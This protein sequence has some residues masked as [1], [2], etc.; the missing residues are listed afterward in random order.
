[1]KT[2]LCFGQGGLLAILLHQVPIG[3]TF[4]GDASGGDKEGGRVVLPGPQIRPDE[5]EI[6]RLQGI[7]FGDG[8]FDAWD[9]N[10]ALLRVHVVTLEQRHFGGPEAVMIGQL[11]EGTVTLA[12][13]D[14]KQPAHLVLSEKGDRGW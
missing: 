11:K 10:A 13:D 8:A 3:P 12:G 4:Q 14:G 2:S 1:M 6:L 7:G 5:P 9:I